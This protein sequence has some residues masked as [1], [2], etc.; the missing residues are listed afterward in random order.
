M[1]ASWV[2]LAQNKIYTIV[3]ARTEKKLI[4]K[5]PSL[6]FTNDEKSS[7]N[8]NNFPCVYV[9]FQTGNSAAGSLKANK[10]NAFRCN[11]AIYVTAS[12]SQRLD[13]AFEV[14]WEVLDE[15]QKLGFEIGT[16]EESGTGG[17]TKQVVARVRRLIGYNDI[18]K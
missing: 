9:R 3:K 5:Y 14:M 15:F 18:I 6:V 13:G 7:G 10:I 8:T 11:M 16:P 12:K 4:T 1:S 17:D 2:Y